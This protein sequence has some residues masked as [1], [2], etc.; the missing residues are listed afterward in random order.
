MNKTLDLTDSN[1]LMFGGI[2][3]KEVLEDH[4]VNRVLL[5]GEGMD[6]TYNDGNGTIT[7]A[8]E[9]ATSLNKGVASFDSSE[10]TVTSGAVTLSTIDGGTF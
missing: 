3:W 9:L 8:A 4:L 7:F 2:N 6:I 1:S 10:F 5:E